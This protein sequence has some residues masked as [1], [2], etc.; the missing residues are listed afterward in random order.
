MSTTDHSTRRRF[1]GQVGAALSGPLAAAAALAV[2]TCDAAADA[3]ATQL[4]ALEDVNAIRTLQRAYARLVNSG[5]HDEAARLF[6]D[7]SVAP[8]DNGVRRLAADLFAAHDAVD[9]A[10]DGRSATA[11]LECTVEIET[12]IDGHGTLLEMLRQQGEGTRRAVEPRVLEAS[13]VKLGGAWRI[14]SLALSPA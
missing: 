5:A 4:A 7:P 2:G 13:Y 3:S 14:G 1:F 12:V 11:R 9:V 8:G 6:V 10:P